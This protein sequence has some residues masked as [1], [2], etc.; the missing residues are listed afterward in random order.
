MRHIR[1]PHYLDKFLEIS[2][3]PLHSTPPHPQPRQVLHVVLLGRHQ[4][5][6]D[7]LPDDVLSV[8]YSGCLGGSSVCPRLR[9]RCFRAV[10]CDHGGLEV[11]SGG[12]MRF[13]TEFGTGT[14]LRRDSL[15]L[16]VDRLLLELFLLLFHSLFFFLH[17]GCD[18]LFILYSLFFFSLCSGRSFFTLCDLILS[19]ICVF[20]CFVMLRMIKKNDENK[21]RSSH[22]LFFL[23]KYL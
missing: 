22:R 11:F 16:E 5:V 7:S 19:F 4:L 6:E 10:L 18:L 20:L 14:D 21:F 15:L 8:L 12:K 13:G 9:P 17:F 3:A 23:Y 2:S 1:R